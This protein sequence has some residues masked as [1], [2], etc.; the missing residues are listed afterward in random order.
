M[1]YKRSADGTIN[2]VYEYFNDCEISVIISNPLNPAGNSI[3]IYFHEFGVEYI[4]DDIM[5]ENEI[6]ISTEYK[7][8]WF[9]WIR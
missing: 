1:H 4:I 8:S 3:R 2:G 6:G 5:R 7:F 9:E